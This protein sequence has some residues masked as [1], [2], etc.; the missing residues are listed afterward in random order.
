MVVATGDAATENDQNSRAGSGVS[1]AKPAS[2][3]A[4]FFYRHGIST[5]SV[6]F[7]D[8]QD[9]YYFAKN[10]AG[11]FVWGNRL[12]QEQHSLSSVKDIIGKSD[13]DFFRRDIADRIRADDLQ[14]MESLSLIHI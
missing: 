12:L 4:D 6:L 13:H 14:V 2:D 5:P 9:T 1:P 8:L 10:R 7:D 3:C 11:Q